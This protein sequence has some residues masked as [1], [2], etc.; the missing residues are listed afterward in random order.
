MPFKWILFS[1]NYYILLLLHIPDLDQKPPCPHQDLVPF[2]A[3]AQGGGCTQQPP[4]S[5]PGGGLAQWGVFVSISMSKGLE[6]TLNIP[7]PPRLMQINNKA[8]FSW[9]ATAEGLFVFLLT[10]GLEGLGCRTAQCCLLT[11]ESHVIRFSEFATA[12]SN[13]ICEAPSHQKANCC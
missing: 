7:S 4:T 8:I 2:P 6:H 11:W 1:G 5:L 3:W 9:E 10:W 13:M 12:V